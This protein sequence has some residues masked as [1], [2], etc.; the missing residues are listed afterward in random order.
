MKTELC[1]TNTPAGFVIHN[2]IPVVFQGRRLVRLCNID[3][4]WMN[5]WMPYVISHV[6]ALPCELLEK[7][8][9]YWYALEGDNEEFWARRFLR[10]CVDRRF[11]IMKNYWEQTIRAATPFFEK[12]GMLSFENLL[13]DYP[14]DYIYNCDA[15][16]TGVSKAAQ[17]EISVRFMKDKMKD[18]VLG[19]M[20]VL[21]EGDILL[22]HPETKIGRDRTTGAFFNNF[23]FK[24]T[25]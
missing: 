5:A 1:F 17:R 9:M 22:D 8:N 7:M 3:D 21:L 2:L 24:G 18:I 6:K 14:R 23:H 20:K 25:S 4:H 13:K 15:F 16:R 11:P 12:N 10:H 19:E